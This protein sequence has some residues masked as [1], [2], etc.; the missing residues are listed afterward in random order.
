[1][2]GKTSMGVS[3]AEGYRELQRGLAQGRRDFPASHQKVFFDYLKAV[4]GYGEFGAGRGKMVKALEIAEADGLFSSV[5]TRLPWVTDVFLH[6]ILAGAEARTVALRELLERYA[7]SADVSA[8]AKRALELDCS[9]LTVHNAG[10]RKTDE[11]TVLVTVRNVLDEVIARIARSEAEERGSKS[12]GRRMAFGDKLSLV[13]WCL[14][15]LPGGEREERIGDV[16]AA[17]DKVKGVVGI[18]SKDM[19]EAEVFR[20]KYGVIP[21]AAG[22]EDA[23]SALRCVSIDAGRAHEGFVWNKA[24]YD[25][26]GFAVQAELESALKSCMWRCTCRDA[27]DLRKACEVVLAMNDVQQVLRLNAVSDD[28]KERIANGIVGMEL[29]WALAYNASRR[30]NA[31]GSGKVPAFWLEGRIGR[32]G[33]AFEASESALYSVDNALDEMVEEAICRIQVAREVNGTN[34][35]TYAAFR[36]YREGEFDDT[37]LTA[38]LDNAIANRKHVVVCPRN[39]PTITIVSINKGDGQGE[40]GKEED[41]TERIPAPERHDPRDFEWHALGVVKQYA[42]KLWDY[43][44][45]VEWGISASDIDRMRRNGLEELAEKYSPHDVVQKGDALKIVGAKSAHFVERERMALLK[46]LEELPGCDQRILA[47]RI[48]NALSRK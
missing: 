20:E 5:Q 2:D 9:M 12:T 8:M 14:K 32:D 29:L 24:L 44:R 6:G 17:I 34:V 42:P 28:A 45:L 26:V 46:V 18:S 33:R 41:P 7:E 21:I 11:R 23:Y 22:M 1:M 48:K 10:A 30:L 15:Y 25:E 27:A 38:M 40:D 37:Y 16:L 4:A 35:V 47:E 31:R 36:E 43:M 3:A 39:G 13:R 19:T